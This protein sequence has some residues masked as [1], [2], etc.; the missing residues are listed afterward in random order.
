MNILKTLFGSRN[1]RVI[2]RMRKEVERINA[3]EPSIAALNDV[4]LRAKTDE[5][6]NRLAQGEKGPVLASEITE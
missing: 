2:R 4:D 3:L 6:K 1:D 5:F